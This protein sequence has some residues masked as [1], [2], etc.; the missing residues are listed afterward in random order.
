MVVLPLPVYRNL[1]LLKVAMLAGL[2]RSMIE[3]Y[4]QLHTRLGSIRVVTA[5]S[6]VA[7]FLPSKGP[8]FLCGC[9]LSTCSW[10]EPLAS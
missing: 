5:W 10:W 9:R 2:S 7:R 6:L 3:S 8:F 1:C 4:Q